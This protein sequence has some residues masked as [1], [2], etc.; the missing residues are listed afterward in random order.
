MVGT[1]TC[2]ACADT[3]KDITVTAATER[4]L[5]ID[6]WPL[7]W[8]WRPQLV[9]SLG[10]AAIGI[11]HI[12]I[13]PAPSHRISLLG[14]GCQVG[15]RNCNDIA[16]DKPREDAELSCFQKSLESWAAASSQ[17]YAQV[18]LHRVWVNPRAGLGDPVT[19]WDLM[20]S[21]ASSW[22]IAPWNALFMINKALPPDGEQVRRDQAWQ[23]PGGERHPHAHAIGCC[24]R[25][26]IV[27]SGQHGLLWGS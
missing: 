4:T 9:R 13:K 18:L 12:A 10:L 5:I 16:G 1:L 17:R 20:P 2:P 6:I 27:A 21:P 7:G 22:K 19:S 15:S 8:L 24:Y 14:V 23:G 11:Q 3:A 26:T 25:S